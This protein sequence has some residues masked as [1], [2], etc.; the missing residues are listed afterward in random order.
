[1]YNIG[2]SIREDIYD[3]LEVWLPAIGIQVIDDGV[4]W[5]A[6]LR[7]LF[8]DQDEFHLFWVGWAPDYKDPFNML[9]LIFNPTSY[10]NSVQVNDTKLNNLLNLALQTTDDTARNT[11]YKNIQWYLSN[12]LFPQC[13]GYHSKMIYV[14]KADLHGVQY[15]ALNKVYVYPVYRV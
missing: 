6:F 11:I 15:N 10:A 14:H 1:T 9:D 5:A 7:K 3:A 8:E 4:I 13:F 2:N 12:R